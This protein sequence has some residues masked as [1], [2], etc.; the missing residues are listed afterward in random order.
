MSALCLLMARRAI[1]PNGEPG[2]GDRNCLDR[3]LLI[4]DGIFFLV[5]IIIGIRLPLPL[6]LPLVHAAATT[7]SKMAATATATAVTRDREDS[8]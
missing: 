2:D 1:Q 8:E 7:P 6:P 5:S 3:R 4:H